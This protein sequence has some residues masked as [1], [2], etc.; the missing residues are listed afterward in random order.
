M[1]PNPLSSKINHFTSVD[2]LEEEVQ[3]EEARLYNVA[4]YYRPTMGQYRKLLSLLR[5]SIQSH[6]DDERSVEVI[7][8]TLETEIKKKYR[9]ADECKRLSSQISKMALRSYAAIDPSQIL[10]RFGK[11]VILK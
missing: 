6:R 4:P 2:A 1:N 10:F 7:T 8:Q 9:L 5:G 3:R 11:L